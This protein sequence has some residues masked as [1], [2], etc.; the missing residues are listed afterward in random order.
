MTRASFS[1]VARPK[2]S[3]NDSV[4]TALTKDSVVATTPA[5]MAI[6]PA[7]SWIIP[8]HE[9]AFIARSTA[10]STRQPDSAPPGK[11]VV[12]EKWVAES[13]ANMLWI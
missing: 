7:A 11:V 3:E 9:A 8:L 4:A 2:G 13:S 12:K 10:A 6:E 5:T 1:L